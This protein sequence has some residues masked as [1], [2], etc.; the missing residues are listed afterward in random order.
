MNI[1]ELSDK[2]CGCGTC[3]F[4]C[5][6]HCIS[7]ETNDDG[8]WY[9][10]INDNECINCGLCIKRCPVL[11]HTDNVDNLPTRCFAVKALDESIVNNSSSGGFFS[12]IASW[13][14]ENNGVVV[15]A[16]FN[17]QHQVVH[18]TVDCVE[19]LIKLRGSKYVQSN[20][21]DIIKKMEV[22]FKQDKF[23]LFTGTPCQVQAIINYFHG[24]HDKLITADIVCHGVPSPKLW[25]EYI[26]YQQDK[27]HAQV[28]KV[29]FRDKSYGWEG[30]SLYLKFENGKEY[31]KRNQYDPYMRMFLQNT[32]LRES[33]YQCEFKTV[34]KNSDFTLSDFWRVSHSCPQ[35]DDN[36]G[37]SLVFVHSRRGNELFELV[38]NN[39]TSSE[40]TIDQALFEN[41]AILHSAQCPSNRKKAFEQLGKA[42]FKEVYRETCIPLWR[43]MY[44]RIKYKI[45]QELIK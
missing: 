41:S 11:T 26:M 28:E 22:Y 27:Y 35:M 43:D 5:P 34:K 33:C 7:M 4:V 40:I 31:K 18:R 2:C 44:R 24:K 13:V 20:L 45:R 39:I 23:V 8:F 19:D 6:H 16:A 12:I 1:G 25:K 15:G 14:L 38:K 32:Y 17:E 10:E 37:T 21:E 9:P 29:N 42:P 30:Y 36:R 3:E